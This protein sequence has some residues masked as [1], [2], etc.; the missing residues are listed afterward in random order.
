MTVWKLTPVDL[1][2]SNW[3]ASSHRGEV[4]VRA[5]SEEAARALAAD[6]FNVATRFSPGAGIQAPPWTRPS[7]VRA[8]RITDERYPPDG[9]A[10][11][12]QP[13]D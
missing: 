2:D 13:V 6:A 1:L 11:V 7:C 10:E 5:R 3:N 8:E 4:I 9:P 12:L